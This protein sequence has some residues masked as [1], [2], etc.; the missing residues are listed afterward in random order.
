MSFALV[1]IALGC[2]CAV[3]SSR[4]GPN[5]SR[6]ASGSP[7]RVLSALPSA[8]TIPPRPSREQG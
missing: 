4:L 2:P 1:K 7:E 8:A 3:M 6:D 5:G